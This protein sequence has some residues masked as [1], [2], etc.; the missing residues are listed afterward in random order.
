MT[1]LEKFI[2]KIMV[3][4]ALQPRYRQP[5]DGSDGTCDCV[6]L[7]I[8]AFRRS[9]IKWSGIHG[10]N[11]FARKEISGLTRIKSQ[12]EL[13]VGDA[14]FQVFEPGQAGYALPARYKK[15]GQY[16]NGDV[17]DYM[18]IGIVTSINPFGITH[19]WKPSVKTDTSIGKYW[20]YKGWLKKLGNE[21]TIELPPLTPQVNC[22]ARVTAKSGRYVKMRKEPSTRC[23]YYEE[24]PI[25]AIVTIEEPG[26]EW[27]RISYGK[28]HNYYMMAQFLDIVG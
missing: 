3:I 1:L 17:R 4:K 27:A 25:G 28:Y 22:K 26:E 18:H 8:G 19:M 14:V 12:D 13:K 23:R 21:P 9:G 2:Q 5:G 6:G 11:W 20:V 10:S 15:G 7:V 24:V 16:Y